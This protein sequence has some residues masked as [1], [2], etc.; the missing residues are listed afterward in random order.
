MVKHA[1]RMNIEW[2]T[3]CKIDLGHSMNVCK[4]MVK[5]RGGGGMAA[6]SFRLTLTLSILVCSYT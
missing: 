6:I 4:D 2:A 3:F 1:I 5:R